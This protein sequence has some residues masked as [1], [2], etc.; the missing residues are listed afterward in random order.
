MDTN[1]RFIS[2]L[3]ERFQSPT[4]VYRL[5]HE[6]AG[7][8]A[9]NLKMWKSRIL[10]CPAALSL[11]NEQNSDGGWGRFHSRQTNVLTKIPTTE[12]AV[13]RAISLGIDENDPILAR[14]VTYLRRLVFENAIPDPEEKNPR[15]PIGVQLFLGATAGLACR[16]ATWIDQTRSLWGK[17]LTRTF[18]SGHYNA[19]HERKAH[20]ELLGIDVTNSYL[21]YPNRY[22]FELLGTGNS[23]EPDIG[24]R[25]IEDLITHNR[26]IG[27]LDHSLNPPEAVTSSSVDKW[28]RSW[29]VVSR[30]NVRSP[31]ISNVRDWITSQR[32]DYGWD[33][34]AL[35]KNEVFPL[36]SDWRIKQR[37]TDDWTAR[38]LLLLARLEPT[39]C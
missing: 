4:I 28:L 18:R 6:I 16:D 11:E 9:S 22:Q 35:R 33:F 21:A 15:W 20:I 12:F 25:M 13:R 37:R 24:Q 34:G 14:A 36:S 7:E 38:V 19:E 8:D 31:H 10:D 29:E 39:C 27:Y 26:K 3:I 17:I 2:E 1:Q 32:C 23:L 30:L 5:R